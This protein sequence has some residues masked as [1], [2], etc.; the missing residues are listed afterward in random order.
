MP[1]GANRCSRRCRRWKRRN[2]M[3]AEE[4]ASPAVVGY[5]VRDLFFQVRITEALR[6]LG[7]IGRRVDST[8]SIE[9]LDGMVVDLSLPSSRWQPLIE[10]AKATQVPVLAFG[11]HMDQQKWQQAKAAGA[12]RVVANSQM[13]ERLPELIRRLLGYEQ[14]S[15]D[16][17]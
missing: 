9:A 14:V 15:S 5:V 17:Q 6:R 8:A 10:A 1:V 13:T 16:A 12:G 2:G 3:T 4:H 7:M 11:S